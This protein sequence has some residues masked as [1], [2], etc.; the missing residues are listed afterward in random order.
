MV[1]QQTVN[2]WVAGSSPALGANSLTNGSSTH[3]LNGDENTNIHL[4]L[5]SSL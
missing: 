4:K 3:A 5:Y 2:L 1:V